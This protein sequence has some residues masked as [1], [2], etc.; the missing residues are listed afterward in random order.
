MGEFDLAIRAYLCEIRSLLS[1]QLLDLVTGNLCCLTLDVTGR[2]KAQLFDGPV[3]GLV[4]LHDA[5]LATLLRGLLGLPMNY[6]ACLG[7]LQPPYR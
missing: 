6:R 7:A 2:Q 5:P 4:M 1:L 3:D